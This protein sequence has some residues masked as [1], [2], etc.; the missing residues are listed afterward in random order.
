VFTARRPRW[1]LAAAGCG[2][3][4]L[5][6]GLLLKGCM[7]MGPPEPRAIAEAFRG[8]DPPRAVDWR[9]EGRPMHAMEV[10]DSRLPLVVFVHGTPGEW[11]AFMGYLAD[12]ALQR[13]AH[14][15]S[16]DRLGFGASGAGGVE[17][18]LAKQAAA[19]APL[20][21]RGDAGRGAI[22][23]G[24]SL[25]G[26]IVARVAMDFP[27]RVGGL[28]IVAGSCDPELEKRTWYQ[29]AGMS[30]LVRWAVPR[31]LDLANVEMIP[32]K[33]ELAAMLPRWS[34][35]RVPVTVIQG[36]KDSLVPPANADFLGRVLVHAP[37]TMVRP[38]AASHFLLW[39][40]PELVRGA[41]LRMLAGDRPLQSGS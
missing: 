35:I 17:T 38:A 22:L 7:S 32:L 21:E 12:P 39:E 11:S 18:S 15:I 3:S 19:L 36:G 4:L 28:V 34:E 14:M 29:R 30:P 20:L 9:F 33:G 25:G 13:V 5:A 8:V 40:Q 31:E 16:V 6:A 27:A 24:H 2:V 1:T 10:G 23:V 41:L 26:P 37:L